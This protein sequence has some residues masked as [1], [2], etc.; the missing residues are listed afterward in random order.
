MNKNDTVIASFEVKIT[1]EG[2]LILETKLA[3]S[4][5]FTETMDKWNPE[6]ENT[7]VIASML[8]YY[9]GVF[10]LMIKDSQK[11]TN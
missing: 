4:F 8:D 5:E 9:S 10:N 6:Y 11:L 3:D 2:L 1:T 7:P